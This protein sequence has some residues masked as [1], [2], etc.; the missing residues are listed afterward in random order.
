MDALYN[1][2]L[3]ILLLS[4]I[5][6][7]LWSGEQH[8]GGGKEGE[9]G[10]LITTT[11][12]CNITCRWMDASYSQPVMFHAFPVVKGRT[13]WG[14]GRRKRQLN[15]NNTMQCSVT[16]RWMDALYSLAVMFHAIPVVKG[17]T[18]WGGGRRKRQLNNNDAMQCN[19]TC[20]W[21]DAL[22]SLAVIFHA[23]PVV[24]GRTTWG[25]KGRTAT[26]EQPHNATQ[27]HLQK[28]GCIILTSCHVSCIPSCEGENNMKGRKEDTAT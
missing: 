23:F 24:K 4:S 20:N 22:Y 18:A 11:M 13:T 6:F 15:Y 21:M 3:L 27:C 1:S 25:G 14:R 26:K 5:H 16:C 12:Q 28:N 10:N 19:V 9:N 7:Q 17:R 8:V 2:T